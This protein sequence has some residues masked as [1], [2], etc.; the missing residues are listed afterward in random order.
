MRVSADTRTGVATPVE[1]DR[2]PDHCPVCR[3]GIHP[4]D[5]NLRFLMEGLVESV[6]RCPRQECEFLFIGRY[7]TWHGSAGTLKGNLHQCVPFTIQPSTQ[8][9]VIKNISP[10]FSVIFSQAEEAEQRDLLLVCGPGY[11][12]ALEFLIKDYIIRSH[13]DEADAIKKML[14]GKCISDYVGSDRV[15]Q[16]AARAVW[17]GN[18]ETHYLR[19]WESKDLKDLKILI[20]LTVHWI[21]ME[22]LTETV[23]KDMP[24]G[25]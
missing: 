14:F 10:D 1:L 23:M 21:E 11:R 9:E 17:L 8:K 7:R 25:K 13:P 18:D 22:E 19:K 4:I 5:T 6:Y 2:L 12:K 3:K 20:Q 24:V 15:K 16:V